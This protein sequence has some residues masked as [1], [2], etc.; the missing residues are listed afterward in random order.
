MSSN[1]TVEEAAASLSRCYYPNR[2]D[3]LVAIGIGKWN[4]SDCIYVYT[5][6]KPSTELLEMFEDGWEG[7]V[8]ILRKSG[9]IVAN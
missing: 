5:K 6:N 2:P 8:V 9:P 1:V 7:Y 4:E 3:W